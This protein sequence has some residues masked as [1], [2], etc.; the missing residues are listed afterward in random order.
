MNVLIVSDFTYPRLGGVEVHISHL[1]SNLASTHNHVNSVTVLTRHDDI[2]GERWS[3]DPQH[4][5]DDQGG[6]F[7]PV[8]YI[9]TPMTTMGAGTSLVNFSVSCKH[10]HDVIKRRRI[11]VV[12][13]HASTSV[14]AL[15]VALYCRLLSIPMVHTEHR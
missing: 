4:K 2:V 14:M 8:L 11:N 10:F 15:E 12:H 9:Y 5:G 13:T 7:K 3:T 6:S 1:A